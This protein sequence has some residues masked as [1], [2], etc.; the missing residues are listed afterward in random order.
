MASRDQILF[1][2]FL[3]SSIHPDFHRYI[4]VILRYLFHWT[5]YYYFFLNLTWNKIKITQI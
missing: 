4:R 3:L 5:N 1:E 2:I